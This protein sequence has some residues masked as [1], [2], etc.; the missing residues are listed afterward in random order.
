MKIRIVAALLTM[1]SLSLH[2]QSLAEAA[3]KAEEAHAAAAAAKKPDDKKTAKP[4][5]KTAFTDKDLEDVSALYPSAKPEA[6][7]AGSA[8]A[9]AATEPTESERASDYRTTAKKDEAYWKDRMRTLHATLDWTQA[10]LAAA[11]I[12]ER[13]LDKR[14]HRSVDDML[15]TRDRLLRAQVDAQWQDAVAEASRLKA[16]VQNGTK[17]IAD[18]ELEAHRAGVPPGWLVLP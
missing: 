4:A 3:K 6:A 7:P 15:Y 1:L 13:A 2:A 18:A 17:L 9:A 11:I 14:I 8:P 10:F 5:P 12:R 16:A